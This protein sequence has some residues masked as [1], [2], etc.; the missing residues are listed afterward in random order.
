MNDDLHEFVLSIGDHFVML[1]VVESVTEL[2]LH[3]C[4]QVEFQ[5]EITLNMDFELC[6][7]A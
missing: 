7:D 3:I 4:E 6:L 5:A 1:P 2:S